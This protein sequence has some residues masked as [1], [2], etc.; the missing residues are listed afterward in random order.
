MLRLSR[1]RVI[2]DIEFLVGGLKGSLERREWSVAGVDCWRQRHS[3]GAEV[4]S[5]DLDVLRVRAGGGAEGRWELFVVTEFWR[6]ADGAG[7]HSAKWLKLV[8]G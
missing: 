7:L 2:G 1:G 6:S 8:S 3:Y 5:F 4:Y